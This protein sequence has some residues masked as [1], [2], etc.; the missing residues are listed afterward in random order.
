M[1]K[2]AAAVAVAVF[3]AT[4]LAGEVDARS[5]F[6][7]G[8]QATYRVH[9]LGLAAGTAQVTVGAEMKMWGKQVW[10]IVT[11][12]RTESVAAVYPIRDKFVTYWDPAVSRT[13][14]SDLYADENR[15]KRRQRIK[16]N[17]DGVAEV[18]KQREGQ[19]EVL[20]RHEVDPMAFDIASAALALRSRE[21][22]VGQEHELPVFTGAKSFVLRAKVESKESL[23]TSLGER[24]VFK[25]RASTEFSGKLAAKQDTIV[26]LTT[27]PTHLLVR[28]EAEFLIGSLVAELTDYKPGRTLALRTPSGG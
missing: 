26:Y 12:A 19:D 16:L 18:I 2:R 8:E 5:A 1:K 28:M 21:L 17:G 22:S 24:E 7:P 15:K 10:P 23:Q 11:L 9:Y 20:E 27:D 4:A 14:G 25:V 13:I 6:G 3:S